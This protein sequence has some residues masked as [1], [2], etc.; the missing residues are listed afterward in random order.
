[1]NNYDIGILTFWNVPNYGTYAQAYALQKVIDK[2]TNYDVRQINHLDQHHYNYYFNKKMYYKEIKKYKIQYWKNILKKYDINNK[3]EMN[4]LKAYELIPHT[5]EIT[6]EN[7][8][9]FKFKKIFLGSDIVWDYRRNQFNHDPLLFGN[10]FNGEINSYAASFGTVNENKKIPEYVIDGISRMK[11]IS[12]RDEKSAN[13]IKGI[14][15]QKV[16]IVLDPVWL[17]DFFNDDNI[18]YPEEENYILIY[19]QDFT[20]EYIYNLIEYA[21]KYKLKTIALDCNNDT[22]KWC[23]ILIKQE[24]L[25]PMEWM[26]YFLKSSIVATSTFH[27]LTFGLLFNKKVAFCKTEFI[28]AKVEGLLRELGIYDIFDESSNIYKMLEFDWNKQYEFINDIINKK[29]EKSI[30]FIKKCLEEK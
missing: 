9:N 6:Y 3:R 1:M 5:D 21:K 17:W 29:K 27:G 18:V 13:I 10:N 12:V 11:N 8:K 20:E 16:D 19:G 14:T 15:G 30:N 4:F 7:V 25:N 26:G 23:D 2:M 28:L 22:Y 24:D